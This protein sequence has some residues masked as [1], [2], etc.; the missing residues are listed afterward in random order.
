MQRDGWGRGVYWHMRHEAELRRL[1]EAEHASLVRTAYL[2]GRDMAA[3]E[4]VVAEAFARAAARWW[5]IRRYDRPGAWL[6]LVTVR[7]AV[8]ARDRAARERASDRLPDAGRFDPAPP[9][10]ELLAAL[11]ALTPAQRDCVVLHH[12]DDLGVDHIADALGMPAGTVRSHL[13]RGRVRLAELLQEAAVP[14][15]EG[16]P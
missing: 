10:P 1:Y 6:R 5:R 3:A 4:D 2:I 11:D 9:D 13:H 12:L 7:L 8:R 16:G 15:P 14:A